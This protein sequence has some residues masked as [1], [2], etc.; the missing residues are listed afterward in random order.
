MNKPRPIINALTAPYWQAASRGELALQRCRS[1]RHWIH[2]PEPRC[3]QCGSQS[4]H[5][6]KVSGKGVIESFS[7]IHR[8][9]VEGFNSEPY[10]IA[11]VSLPEQQSLR[12][13]TNIINCNVRDIAIDQAVELCFQQRGEFGQLPQFTLSLNS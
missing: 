11:W 12:V 3:P 6:E 5:Y 10:T 2:F 8:S 1:C 13:M 9:F 4:L 7:E